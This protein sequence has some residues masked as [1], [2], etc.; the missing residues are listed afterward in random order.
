MLAFE[1]DLGTALSRA[2]TG[3]M[4]DDALHL[5][6]A[7]EVVWRDMFS[8]L[9]Q[10]GG[11]LHKMH[12]SVPESLLTMVK[13]VLEGH[14]TSSTIDVQALEESAQAALTIGQLMVFNSVKH[15]RS[16]ASPYVIR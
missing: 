6:R 3:D 5:A 1:S 14:F 16:T 10:F 12:K 7:A 11:S 8:S 13:M 4:D 9:W 2:C 15:K